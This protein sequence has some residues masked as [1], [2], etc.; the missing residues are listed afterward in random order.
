[1]KRPII[2]I[3]A[4]YIAGQGRYMLN[5]TYSDAVER[6]GGL[7]LVLPFRTDPSLIPQMVDQLDGILF[8]GGA[9]MNSVH[10]NEPLHPK[11]VP[12]DP[13][14]ERFELAL[15]R[16]VDRRRVPTLAICM[17]AQVMNVCRG[18]SLIQFLPDHERP[19]ALEHRAQDP[20]DRRHAVELRPGSML[21]GIIG[22]SACEVNTRHKQA[23]ARTGTG[24]QV[25]ATALDG[26]VEAI[27]DPTA[28][29]FIGVQWHPER[30]VE[31]GEQLALFKRLVEVAQK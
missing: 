8:S 24:L 15:M 3:T 6:A 28:P 4:D 11:V 13:Q 10:W 7:P 1:M 16:E 5:Y 25:V 2:G 27:E 14:R 9:D 20:D 31:Q 18:G 26:V 22:G 21:G 12:L 23:I 17:G 19:G 29:L 30:L